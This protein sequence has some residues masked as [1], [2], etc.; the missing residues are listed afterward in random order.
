MALVQIASDNFQ[1]ANADPIGS[2]WTTVSFGGYQ[3]ISDACYPASLG[4]CLAENTSTS[5]LGANQAASAIVNPANVGNTSI[6]GVAL[7][8]QGSSNAYVLYAG[9]SSLFIQKRTG[10]SGFSNVASAGVSIPT[11]STILFTAIGTNLRGYVNNTLILNV[12]DSSITGAGLAG[13]SSFD[14]VNAT[15]SSISSWAAY[16]IVNG[17]GLLLGVG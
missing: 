16:K 4:T 3:I 12:N 8:I 7:R 15:E 17:G 6:V 1:R 10:G 5:G 2:P 9:H 14:S 13:M 11:G